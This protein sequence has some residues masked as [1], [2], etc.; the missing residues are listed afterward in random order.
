MAA[1]TSTFFLGST[2]LLGRRGDGCS[3]RRCC[4]VGRLRRVGWSCNTRAGLSRRGILSGATAL[5]R[6][7]R[8]YFLS[9][10]GRLQ[11]G[12]GQVAIAL[13]RCCH[14]L[15]WCRR[16]SSGC[17]CLERCFGR[18]TPLFGRRSVGISR[19]SRRNS[20]CRSSSRCD[21]SS[22]RSGSGFGRSSSLL[23]RSWAR[24]SESS[25]C[26]GCG[27]RRCRWLDRL[28]RDF[29]LDF[30]RTSSFSWVAEL[31]RRPAE[32]PQ[33]LRAQGRERRE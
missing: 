7:W 14:L 20:A 11:S 27:W 12:D 22:C 5:L 1:A 17:S 19:C 25:G 18:A 29:R 4:N 23:G 13:R 2:S 33:E 6:A 8:G 28:A 16:S 21:R 15:R 30:R 9:T 10:C 31:Q 3:R 24:S 32:E 26:S